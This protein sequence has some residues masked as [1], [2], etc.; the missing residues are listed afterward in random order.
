[1][2]QWVTKDSLVIAAHPSA[3]FYSLS[4]GELSK[5]SLDSSLAALRQDDTGY[6]EDII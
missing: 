4:F 6:V 2:G 3:K 5:E 1:M